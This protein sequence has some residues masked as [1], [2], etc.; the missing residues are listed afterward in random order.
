MSRHF[1]SYI[2]KCRMLSHYL[3]SPQLFQTIF[4]RFVRPFFS[5]F[6]EEYT[7]YP[8]NLS[9]SKKWSTYISHTFDKS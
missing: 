8:H 1:K 6:C 2:W 4:V 9:K 5:T 7:D 3:L